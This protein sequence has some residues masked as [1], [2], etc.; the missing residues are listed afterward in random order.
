MSTEIIF[1]NINIQ[2]NSE[3]I[4]TALPKFSQHFTPTSQTKKNFVFNYCRLFHIPLFVLTL[5]LIL[6]LAG[7]FDFSQA[8][9]QLIK[10]AQPW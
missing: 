5:K 3:L 8:T 7:V 2:T 9:F 6:R 4:C 1:V 10:F